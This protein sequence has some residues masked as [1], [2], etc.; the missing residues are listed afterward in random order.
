M[1]AGVLAHMRATMR[2]QA[3][4]DRAAS[5]QGKDPSVPPSYRAA[6]DSDGQSQVVEGRGFYIDVPQI[7]PPRCDGNRQV[8]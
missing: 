5:L 3:A 8:L 1:P 7:D 2:M 6:L 4:P